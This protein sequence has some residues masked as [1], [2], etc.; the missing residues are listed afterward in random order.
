M[1]AQNVQK[2]LMLMIME[3]FIVSHVRQV[4]TQIKSDLANVQHAKM[5]P[6]QMW[7]K[8]VGSTE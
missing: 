7:V 1:Y 4:A 8:V 5:I 6:I 2:E 3:A